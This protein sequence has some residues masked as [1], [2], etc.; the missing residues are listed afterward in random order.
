MGAMATTQVNQT[1]AVRPYTKSLAAELLGVSVKQV[2]R[3]ME[4][5]PLRKSTTRVNGGPEYVDGASLHAELA[6]R[7]KPIPQEA[8][9]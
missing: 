8:T 5:G 9:R 7:G 2:E 1:E 3:L 4:D 6:R